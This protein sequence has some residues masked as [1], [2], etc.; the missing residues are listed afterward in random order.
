MV[1]ATG[2]SSRQVAALAEKL[3]VRLKALGYK[4]ILIEGTDQCNWVVVDVGD[5]VI[6][7]FRPEVREFY[8]IEKMWL[9]GADAYKFS[10]HNRDNISAV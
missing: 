1:I 10:T 9:N 7:L 5:A 2:R 6:H 8:N 4:D 3:S